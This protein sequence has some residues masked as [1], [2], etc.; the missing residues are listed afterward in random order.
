MKSRK[1]A[2]VEETKVNSKA[3]LLTYP[4]TEI[5]VG[6]EKVKAVQAIFGKD[7]KRRLSKLRVLL[8]NSPIGGY[9]Y[10]DDREGVLCCNLDY[11]REGDKRHV[12]LDVIHELVHIW[13][14]S[15]GL[16]LFEERFEYINRPT[17]LDAYKVAVAEARRIG[18]SEKEIE[19]YLRVEWVSDKEFAKFLKNLGMK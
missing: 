10:V 6:F 9:M 8:F 2:G 16:E 7:T 12:Y 4:F 3:K 5:F 19:Y 17:E 18:M 13:Q 14:L 1:H 11:L 15:K